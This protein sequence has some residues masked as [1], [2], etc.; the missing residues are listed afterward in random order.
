MSEPV[1]VSNQ[2]TYKIDAYRFLARCSTL[3]GYGKDCLA[4]CQDNVTEWDIRS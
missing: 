4:Q 2:W 3:L 1:V